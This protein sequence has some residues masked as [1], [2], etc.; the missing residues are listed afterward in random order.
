[1]TTQAGGSSYSCNSC[2]FH[3]KIDAHMFLSYLQ[4]SSVNSGI[5][6]TVLFVAR[7]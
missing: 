7:E 4:F 2:P 3:L 6:F 5:P 1:M